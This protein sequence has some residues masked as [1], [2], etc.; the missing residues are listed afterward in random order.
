[1]FAKQKTI[2]AIT[3]QSVQVSNVVLEKPPRKL[4]TKTYP[5]SGKKLVEVIAAIA[6]HVRH[7]PAS[8]LISDDLSYT[9]TLTIPAGTARNNE[10]E[11]VSEQIKTE[12][13]EILENNEWDF[14]EIK[15]N[16]KGKQV[17]VF[18]PV[19]KFFQDLSAA[20][21]KAQ[22]KIEAIE[23]VAIALARHEDPIIGLA[24]KQDIRGKDETVLNVT[25][26]ARIDTPVKKPQPD[27][28]ATGPNRTTQKPATPSRPVHQKKWL[29]IIAVIVLIIAIGIAVFFVSRANTPPQEDIALT[30]TSELTATPEPA[31]EPIAT[32]EPVDFSKITVQV[33]N[34]SGEKGASG[35]VRDSIQDLDFLSIAVDN[36]DSYTYTDTEIQVKESVPDEVFAT[37]EKQLSDYT[38]IKTDPLTN[39]FEYDVLIIVGERN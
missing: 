31:E 35:T 14:K 5:L 26:A 29:I 7:S 23:P 33:L 30:D 8:V 20:T 25:P 24:M 12:I 18:A 27:V 6:P 16:K 10:R 28:P 17:L 9:L 15:T 4:Q 32:P 11:A 1:M 22:L 21:A 2:I 3:K 37:I 34:G 13:P 39:D 19:K 36:A 38:V